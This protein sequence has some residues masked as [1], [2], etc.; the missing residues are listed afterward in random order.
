LNAGYNKVSVLSIVFVEKAG[1]TF[2]VQG[3]RYNQES[4]C[5]VSV[6]RYVHHQDGGIVPIIA[7][8]NQENQDKEKIGKGK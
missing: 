8:L 5:N 2:H 1:V 4:V 7:P 3:N 6:A